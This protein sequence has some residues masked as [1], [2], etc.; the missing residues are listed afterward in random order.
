MIPYTFIRV[1]GVIVIMC[2]GMYYNQLIAIDERLYDSTFYIGLLIYLINKKDFAS[3]LFRV[4]LSLLLWNEATKDDGIINF[5]D[6][7]EIVF[8]IIITSYNIYGS[9]IFKG[10]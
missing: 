3:E 2:T 1:F 4:Y 9:R 8:V 10:N 7:I 6:W 5:I